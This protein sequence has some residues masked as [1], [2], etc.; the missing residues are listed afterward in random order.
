MPNNTISYAETHHVTTS[1][2]ARRENAFRCNPAKFDNI[3]IALITLQEFCHLRFWRPGIGVGPNPL[4][5]NL[6]RIR[7]LDGQDEFV[8]FDAVVLA[9]VVKVVDADHGMRV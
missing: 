3:H 6:I 1:N 5:R 8:H 9:G 7:H 4:P 2:E